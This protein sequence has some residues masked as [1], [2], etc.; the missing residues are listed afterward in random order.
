MIH[1]ILVGDPFEVKYLTAAENGWQN[2]MLLCRGQY[3][4]RIGGRFFQGFQK[5]IKGRW[6]EHVH[7]IYD[8]NFIFPRLRGETHLVNQ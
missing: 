8:I 6:T 5:S 3:E 2:F 1:D 7:F 4:N